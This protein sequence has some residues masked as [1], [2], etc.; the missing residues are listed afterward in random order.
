[1]KASATVRIENNILRVELIKKWV[2]ARRGR[3]TVLA[4]A[5]GQNKNALYAT[6]FENRMSAELVNTVERKKS[7]IEA[8]ERECIKF[9]PFFCVSP[10]KVR[11]VLAS[12]PKSLKH[13][14]M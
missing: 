6:I 11:G 5:T 13:R 2:R 9:F 10:V 12:W 14:R 7:E 1:M 3:M 4:R 8:L